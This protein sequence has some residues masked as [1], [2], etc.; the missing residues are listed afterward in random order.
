MTHVAGHASVIDRMSHALGIA[1]PHTTTPTTT[2]NQNTTVGADSLKS[3]DTLNIK[4]K[5]NGVKSIE[6][7][8]AKHEHT[9][10]Q[11]T[12][13]KYEEWKPFKSSKTGAA[14]GAMSGFPLGLTAGAAAT[15]AVAALSKD[16]KTAVA[17]GASVFVT[18]VVAGSVG[19][20]VGYKARSMNVD[21]TEPP[22]GTM[23]DSPA[24]VVENEK[25]ADAVWKKALG[26]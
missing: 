9:N 18:S 7:A 8:F 15:V 13:K 14:V 10:T 4:S 2:E 20:A 19:G 16:Y 1:K 23:Y 6:L 17:V 11:D 5:G 24:Q 22:M 3:G 21:L 25:R 12:I 26:H